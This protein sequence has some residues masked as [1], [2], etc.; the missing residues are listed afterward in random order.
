MSWCF[1]AQSPDSFD[2][3]AVFDLRPRQPDLWRT[4]LYYFFLGGS[5]FIAPFLNLFY[6]RIGLS[7]AD[8]GL[9]AAVG[10]VVALIAAPLWTN[11]SK[12]RH[13][14]RRLLQTSLVLS[15]LSLLWLGQQRL[16]WGIVLAVA[17]RALVSAGLSPLSDAAALS[18]TGAS[19][20]GFG[21]VRV[22]TSIGWVAAVLLS[23]WLIERTGFGPAFG[24]AA[25]ASFL[26][27]LLLFSIGPRHFSSARTS[28]QTSL[29]LGALLRGLWQNRAMVGAGLMMIII[30]IGNSGVGQFETVYLSTLGA[31]ESLIGIAGMVSAVVEIPCMLWADRLVRR[32]GAHRLLLISMAMTALLR[33]MVV[34]G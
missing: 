29:P 18:V 17:V 8:I 9:T 27:A 1:C 22:W 16:F 2:N 23:G 25:L 10:A 4:R 34:N 33:G 24:G 7:G 12:T 32:Q 11:Q 30:G 20:S 19:K 5:G 31:R 14:P 6:I 15:G 3:M 13:H 28:G 26:G 21:S